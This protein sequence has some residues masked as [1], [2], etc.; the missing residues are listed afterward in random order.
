MANTARENTLLDSNYIDSA[1]NDSSTHVANDNDH[2]HLEARH[3]IADDLK[4]ASSLLYNAYF[5][6]PLFRFMFKAQDEGYEMRLRSAIRE[7]IH[8]FWDSE[9]PI[10]GLYH[11]QRLLAVAC[12]IAPH[13]AFGPERF[14]HWRMKMLLTAG[15]FSTQ[16]MMSKEKQIRAHLPSANSHIISFIAVHPD[17]RRKGIGHVLLSAIDS[18]IADD[19]SDGAAVLVANSEHEA[20]FGQGGYEQ[21]VELSIGNETNKVMYRRFAG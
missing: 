12:L 13:A 5:N 17:Q 10:I 6:D 14:W 7:E 20:F 9:Q 4:V 1:S 15:Y 16:Q 19:N 21:L 3:I 18:I 8:T 11:G 2:A